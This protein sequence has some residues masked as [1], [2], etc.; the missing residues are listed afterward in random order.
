MPLRHATLAETTKA[1][2][3]HLP[4]HKAEEVTY[5]FVYSPATQSDL[6]R[7]SYASRLAPEIAWPQWNVPPSSTVTTQ[8]FFAVAGG[9]SEIIPQ[10]E[11]FV[12]TETA[13]IISNK[14][15]KVLND[16]D[17]YD[18]G[19]QRPEKEIVQDVKDLI[20]KTRIQLTGHRFPEVIV[21][22]LD[23][24]VRLTWASES[25]NVRL[26]YS[27]NENDRYIYHEEIRDG[28][29]GNSGLAQDVSSSSLADWLKW[30]NSR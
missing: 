29:S 13:R 20:A 23:G 27:K 9:T 22:P 18:E 28:K 21:R 3:P 24:T 26:V 4:T 2:I 6:P 1:V 17:M 15:D 8:A 30:L 14:I 19:E 11:R 25:A 5:R 10:T 16:P 12:K 7:I